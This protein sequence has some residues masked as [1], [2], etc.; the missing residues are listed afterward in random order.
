MYLKAARTRNPIKFFEDFVSIVFLQKISVWILLI[1]ET[2]V[3]LLPKFLFLCSPKPGGLCSLR[4]V[5]LCSPKSGDLAQFFFF[6][7]KLMSATIDYHQ[8]HRLGGEMRLIAHRYL[9]MQFSFNTLLP[10]FLLHASC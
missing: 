9:T 8:P 6:F 5:G 10:K 7:R 1:N 2:K 3:D 4:S